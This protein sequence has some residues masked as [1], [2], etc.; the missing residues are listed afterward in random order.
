MQIYPRLFEVMFLGRHVQRPEER[1]L[2]G[3]GAGSQPALKD[4]EQVVAVAN[5]ADRHLV[6]YPLIEEGSQLL[7]RQRLIHGLSL[8]GERHP[9]P[10]DDE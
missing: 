2:F 6:T 4:R 1:R 9:E 7:L 5:D 10:H 8:V 3:F